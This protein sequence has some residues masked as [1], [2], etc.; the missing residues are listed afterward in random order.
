MGVYSSILVV[1]IVGGFL[2]LVTA[3]LACLTKQFD[4][5]HKWHIYSGRLFLFSYIIIFFTALALVFL[6]INYFLLLIAC[7][8]FYLA[9]SGL[10][11][12]KNKKG[13]PTLVDWLLQGCFFFIALFMLGFGVFS[14][15]QAHKNHAIVSFVFGFIGWLFAIRELRSY[16]KKQ[17]VSGRKR[18]VKHLGFMLGATIGTVTAFV[19]TNFDLQP[20]F[21]LWLAPTIFITPYIIYWNRKLLGNAKKTSR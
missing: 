8:S 12:A 5:S 20:A 19:V 16:Q 13:V 11:Y 3:F 18:I 14:W 9:L 1:H 4:L 2:A 17:I 7:F 21:I 15:T 6:K 10:R